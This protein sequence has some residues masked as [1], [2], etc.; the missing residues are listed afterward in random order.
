MVCSNP[1]VASST[2]E[3]EEMR[4]IWLWQQFAVHVTPTVQRVVE[5]AKRVPGNFDISFIHVFSGMISYV[6]VD[7]LNLISMCFRFLSFK[8]RRP[9]NINKNRFFWTLARPS[10]KANVRYYFN[11]LRWYFHHETA[12]GDYVWCKYRMYLFHQLRMICTEFSSKKRKIEILFHEHFAIDM[13][14][15]NNLEIIKWWKAFR[16]T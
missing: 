11:I 15:S 16:S 2:V 10:C 1:E 8:S 13:C 12:N 7:L 14:F 4:R 6:N 9:V 3:N 5:F